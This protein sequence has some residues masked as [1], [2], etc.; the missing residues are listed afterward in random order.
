[1]K[2]EKLKTMIT[3]N[4]DFRNAIYVAY[5]VI[6]YVYLTD[7]YVWNFETRQCS[8]KTKSTHFKRGICCGNCTTILITRFLLVFQHPGCALGRLFSLIVFDYLI[9]SE[10]FLYDFDAHFKVYTLRSPVLA[11]FSKLSIWFSL[12]NCSIA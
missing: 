1:M 11:I 12:C 5:Y 3:W 7:L 10:F 6:W 8:D 4:D 2:S 9:F